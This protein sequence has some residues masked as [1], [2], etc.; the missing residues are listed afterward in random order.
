MIPALASLQAFGPA[1]IFLGSGLE[2]QT[3]A[4]AGGVMARMGLINWPLALAAACAGSAVMDQM[5]FFLGRYGRSTR[6]VTRMTAKPAFARA[7][8]FIEAHPIGFVMS[9]RFIF[10]LRAAGPVAAGLSAM[11][12]GLFTGLNL[13]SAAVWASLFSGG[14]FIFGATLQRWLEHPTLKGEII[15]GA[16]GL[17]FALGM[18]ALALWRPRPLPAVAATP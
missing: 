7:A 13:A 16:V 14:G 1:A 2:G 18:A 15:V 6:F 10:G 9:F 12:M 17:A 5:L 8:A 11:G 3:V 4:I